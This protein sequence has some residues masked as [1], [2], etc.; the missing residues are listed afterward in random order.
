LGKVIWFSNQ[1]KDGRPAEGWDGNFKG[2]PL[3]QGVYIWK[4]RA[5]FNNGA[6]WQGVKVDGKYHREG[7]ITLLK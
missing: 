4:I 5:I 2:K 3:P 1:I 6:T 7:S